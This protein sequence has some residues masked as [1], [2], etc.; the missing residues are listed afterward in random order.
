MAVAGVLIAFLPGALAGGGLWSIP[1]GLLAASCLAFRRRRPV[2]VWAVA[3]AAALVT[4]AVVPSTFLVM[5]GSLFALY[6][7]AAVSPRSASRFAGWATVL[8]VLLAVA[9][10]HLG[11]TA[12][13]AS[14][15][16]AVVTVATW[17]VGDNVRVRRAYVAQLEAAA[18]RAA[19]DRTAE[20]A[21]AAACERERIA[22]ELH[23]VVV[24][25]VSVIAVQAGA[26]R[27]LAE[28]S[29]A[30]AGSTTTW[31]AIEDTARLALTELRH[32][33]GALRHA[34]ER[35]SLA[36]QPGLGQ[37]DQL[38]DEVRAVGLSVRSDLV[39]LP[40]ELPPALDLS[41]YRIIQEALT[42]VIKH[43]GRVPTHVRL[44]CGESTLDVEVENDGGGAAT[45]NSS[46]GGGHGLVGMRERVGVL[47]GSLHAGPRSGGG[48]AVRACLPLD[49]GT[50]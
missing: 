13:L 33:L 7:V 12:W 26:A 17:L 41:A 1:P 37:L 45:V 50:R 47:G 2:A 3:T 27:L 43:E 4:V 44:R 19:A 28:T 34:G 36:P 9:L 24:H 8:A 16:A 25:H 39:G 5:L 35:P 46:E 22:R 48:F 40:M 31:A 6:N 20:L 21:R 49:G 30:P 14:T 29:D 32:L 23:D 15:F 10:G 11:V 38:L 18:S 42:N